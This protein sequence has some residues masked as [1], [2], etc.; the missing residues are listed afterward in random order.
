MKNPDCTLQPWEVAQCPK[1]QEAFTQ[2]TEKT[3]N[4]TYSLKQLAAETEDCDLRMQILSIIEEVTEIPTIL[5]DIG[6]DAD[7][8]IELRKAISMAPEILE[9]QTSLRGGYHL[10]G[11]RHD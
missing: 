10:V 11:E 6:F 8:E 2:V 1:V 7:G 3:V 4:I 5:Q 9:L